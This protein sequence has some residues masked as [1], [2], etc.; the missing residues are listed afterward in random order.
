MQNAVE[1]VSDYLL[2]IISTMCFEIEVK[3]KTAV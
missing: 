3:D 1:N 2:S